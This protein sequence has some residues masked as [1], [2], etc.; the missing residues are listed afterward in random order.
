MSRDSRMMRTHLA[1]LR[2]HLDQHAAA[3]GETAEQLHQ[4]REQLAGAPLADRLA[5]PP[6][7]LTPPQPAENTES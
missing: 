7:D 3:I 5:P 2:E 4:E 1:E 6:I